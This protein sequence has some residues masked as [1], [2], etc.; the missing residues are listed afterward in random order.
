MPTQDKH[1]FHTRSAGQINLPTRQLINSST[2]THDLLLQ[3]TC[4]LI[5]LSTRQLPLMG[6]EYYCNKGDDRITIIQKK[7]QK[8][9]LYFYP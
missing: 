6:T 3:A 5:N 8:T 9:D 2:T 1:L 7:V 4:L